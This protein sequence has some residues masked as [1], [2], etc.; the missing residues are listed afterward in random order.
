MVF[1]NVV[2]EVEREGTLDLLGCL[3]K[4]INGPSHLQ[5]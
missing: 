4:Q 2:T 3:N 1:V 5:S